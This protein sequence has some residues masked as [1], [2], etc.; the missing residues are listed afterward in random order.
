MEEKEQNFTRKKF[1]AEDYK[2]LSENTK[3]RCAELRLLD[4]YVD[5]PKGYKD[6]G[7]EEIFEKVCNE[8]LESLTKEMI[9][10]RIK[11]MPKIYM[12]SSVPISK[13]SLF[14]GFI[15]TNPILPNQ[16]SYYVV[17]YFE[18]HYKILKRRL[19]HG[20]RIS[21]KKPKLH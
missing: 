2:R 8:A 15:K 11:T 1:T 10:S 9:K 18:P 7:T 5:T 4:D 6:Y 14:H 21:K 17:A 3:V 12:V 20:Y 13:E 16:H 19:T